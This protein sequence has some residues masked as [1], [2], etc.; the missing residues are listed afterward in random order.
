MR[1]YK[2]DRVKVVKNPYGAM[3][4]MNMLGMTAVVSKAIKGGSTRLVSL[5]FDKGLKCWLMVDGK[6]CETLKLL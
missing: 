1:L 5:R 2:G 4:G 6:G 3:F